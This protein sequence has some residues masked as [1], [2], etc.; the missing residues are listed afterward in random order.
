MKGK[1][2]EEEEI[3][4]ARLQSALPIFHGTSPPHMCRTGFCD[5]QNETNLI[6]RGLLKPPL[7]LP[8]HMYICKY[9]QIHICNEFTCMAEEICPVSGASMGY[10][11]EYSNYDPND[12]RTWEVN[13]DV[14]NN[15]KKRPIES[16]TEEK[17]E[18]IIEEL[19]YSSKRKKVYEKLYNQAQKNLKKEKNAYLKSCKDGQVNLIK[20][21][22]IITKHSHYKKNALNYHL[23]KNQILLAK[24]TSIISDIYERVKKVSNKKVNIESIVLACLYKMQQ[25]GIPGLLEPD[26]YLARNLPELAH[27]HEFGFNKTKFTDGEK[28]ILQII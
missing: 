2:K 18:Y 4:I 27:L 7:I 8:Y 10:I 6:K 28:L 14:K 15:P 20:L 25:G 5:P 11:N 1:E 21:A 12:P 26:V 19:L 13:K 23:M 16:D 24:Y 9:G 17:I 22:M 3:F